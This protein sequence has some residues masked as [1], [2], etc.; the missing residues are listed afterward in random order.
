MQRWIVELHSDA[1]CTCVSHEPANQSANSANGPYASWVFGKKCV[2]I[3]FLF[4]W[5]NRLYDVWFCVFDSPNSQARRRNETEKRKFTHFFLFTFPF[6]CSINDAH[7]LAHTQVWLWPVARQTMDCRYEICAFR[8]SKNFY[9]GVTSVQYG[10][11]G[12]VCFLLGLV[13]RQAVTTGAAIIWQH[14]CARVRC[15]A[16]YYSFALRAI[17][18]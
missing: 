12:F 16:R 7:A 6:L 14:V 2:S 3:M 9:N 15:L 8:S 10:I 17:R 1:H 11:F 13:W 5:L 4:H 18:V